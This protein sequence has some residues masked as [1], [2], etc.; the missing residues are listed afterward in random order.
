[1]HRFPHY[2]GVNQAGS[3]DFNDWARKVC[4]TDAKYSVMFTAE[5][6]MPNL[7]MGSTFTDG[8][9]EHLIRIPIENYA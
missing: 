4:S 1:M 7:D 9:G 3:A 8:S 6:V 2:S 5:W